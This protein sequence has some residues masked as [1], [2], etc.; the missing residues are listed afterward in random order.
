[1][2]RRRHSAARSATRALRI[3]TRC[4]WAASRATWRPCRWRLTMAIPT[5]AASPCD[6][7]AVRVEGHADM[8]CAAPADVHAHAEIAHTRVR[9]HTYVYVSDSPTGQ[10]RAGTLRLRR[11][12]LGALGWL[13]GRGRGS[14]GVWRLARV[15]RGGAARAGR[16][17]G[18][19]GCRQ[20]MPDA[21]HRL[22][23]SVCPHRSG[24]LCVFT[25]C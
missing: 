6:L 14:A 9:S 25:R 21:W 22:T 23:R 2:I 11:A 17:A 1:M 15:R 4:L 7:A 18:A 13:R 10:G 8:T 5:M 12:R 16:G 24:E 19:V 3:R 20:G